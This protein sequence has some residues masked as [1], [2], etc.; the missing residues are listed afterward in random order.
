MNEQNHTTEPKV[1]STIDGNTLMAQEYEPLQFSIDTILPHGIFVFAGSPKVGKSFLTLDMCRAISTGGKL[2]DFKA[3]QGEALY[4]ALEDR[5]NRLQARLRQIKADSEDISRLHLATA[6]FGLSNGLLEQVHN[7]I[8]EYPG[9]NFIAIDTLEKIRDGGRDRD[10][11]S[12]D[13][14]DMG[15]LR[16]ITEKHRLTL[17]LVHHTRK[18]YDPDP[19]N[20]VSGSTGLIG[21]VDGVFVLI[22]DRRT[23]NSAKLTISNRDTESFCFELRFDPDTCRWDYMGNSAVGGDDDDALCFLLNEFLKED[24]NG[25]A[26]ELCSELKRLNTDFSMSPA[27][28]SKQ[29][30]AISA[31]LKKDYGILFER[32][33]NMKARRIFLQRIEQ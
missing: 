17:L 31:S 8:A 25:T 23:G 4:L 24:W 32:D 22:K 11:Y 15:K 2:W 19:L 10:M 6:S 5:H 28:I 30:S 20:T 26:T 21:A 27:V 16:E 18:M 13:Y 7:F 1:L 29:I 12:C 14:S 3:T 33:R 9:T